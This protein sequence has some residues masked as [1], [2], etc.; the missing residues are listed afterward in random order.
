MHETD[1]GPPVVQTVTHRVSSYCLCPLD[2]F[3]RG[4][5]YTVQGARMMYKGGRLV[6]DTSHPHPAC[7]VAGLLVTGQQ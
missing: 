6:S 5:L 4:T 1:A 3:D 2:S 7:H